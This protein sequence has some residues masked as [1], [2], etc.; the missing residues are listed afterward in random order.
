MQVVGEALTAAEFEAVNYAGHKFRIGAATTAAQCG[1]PESTIKML[2]HWQSS[3]YFNT[4]KL[5]GR[6]SQMRQKCWQLDKIIAT[7]DDWT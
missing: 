5:L 6:P 3:A 4:L 2:G 7:I 1:L